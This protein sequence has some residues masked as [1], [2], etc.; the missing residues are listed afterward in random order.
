MIVLPASHDRLALENALKYGWRYNPVRMMS[1]LTFGNPNVSCALTTGGTYYLA[2]SVCV[3]SEAC[4]LLPRTS[5]PLS[6]NCHAPLACILF[7]QLH[8]LLL[9]GSSRSCTCGAAVHR[10]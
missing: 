8:L 6:L 4:L 3:R 7:L 1:R 10:V 5:L 2:C 9:E